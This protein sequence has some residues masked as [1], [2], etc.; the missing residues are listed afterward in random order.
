MKLTIVLLSVLTITAVTLSAFAQNRALSLDGNSSYMEVPPNPSLDISKELT[1][2]LWFT[3]D[4]PENDVFLIMKSANVI[5]STC[6]YGLYITNDSSRIGF[7]LSLKHSG[8]AQISRVGDFADGRW[9]HLAGTFDGQIMTLYIDGVKRASL[10]LERSDEIVAQ[11][12]PLHIGTWRGMEAFH[13]G[14][15][16]EVRL[17]RVVRS[18]DEIRATM[19]AALTGE[20]EDLAGYWNFDKGEATGLSPDGDDSALYNNA[21]IIECSHANVRDG[22]PPTVIKT[23]PSSPENVP[24]D[25]KEIKFFFSE[26]MGEGWAIEYLDNLPVGSIM[27][28]DNMRAV[29]I[30]IGQ[31][32]QPNTIYFAIL[33]PTVAP[34]Y[35]DLTSASGFFS[36]AQGDLLEEFFF[37]FTT[38]KRGEV[39]ITPPTVTDIA[40]YRANEDGELEEVFSGLSREVPDD[41]TDIKILFSERMREKGNQSIRY[42]DNFPGHNARWNKSEENAMTSATI[43]LREPLAPKSEYYMKLNVVDKKYMDLAGNLLEPYTITFTTTGDGTLVSEK[44]CIATTWGAVRNN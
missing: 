24:V 23:I 18:Q 44:E 30:G 39:D 2:E 20:E 26:E 25:I 14:L 15:I 34:R 32:L 6:L 35:I 13:S 43:H 28:D 19:N 42:S 10:P 17:W 33:N 40:L 8:V 36:D 4:I 38:G 7:Q 31:A 37:T 1:I 12:Y 16:D 29:T 3:N 21:R 11:N 9:H 22:V 41:I 5:F 27:W